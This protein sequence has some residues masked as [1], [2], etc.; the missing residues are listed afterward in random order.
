MSPHTCIIFLSKPSKN[1][2]KEEG[3]IVQVRYKGWWVTHEEKMPKATRAFLKRG[4][5]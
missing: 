1:D 4:R 3:G 2:R 5:H